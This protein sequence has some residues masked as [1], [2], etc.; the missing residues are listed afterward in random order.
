MAQNT[1][2][3]EL[4]TEKVSPTEEKELK[5]IIKDKENPAEYWTNYLTYDGDNLFELYNKFYEDIRDELEIGKSWEE[6]YEEYDDEEE[7][8]YDEIETI[9]LD[10]Q[11]SYLGYVPSKDMFISGWDCWYSSDAGDSDQA[12]GL[13]YF[14]IKKGKIKFV[15]TELLDGDIMYSSRGGYKKLQKK[16]KDLEDIRLD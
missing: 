8:Y 15:N 4:I 9:T 3:K 16:F 6:D 14:Q 12:S 1:H 13:V 7:E 11:E 5:D 10:G 2:F